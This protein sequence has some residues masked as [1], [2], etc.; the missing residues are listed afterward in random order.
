MEQK[1]LRTTAV[2]GETWPACIRPRNEEQKTKQ[3]LLMSFTRRHAR[4]SALYEYYYISGSNSKLSLFYDDL[5]CLRK[6]SPALHQWLLS[7]FR[8][9]RQ[10]R[11]INHTLTCYLMK[12]NV[13][14]PV[15][16]QK[17]QKDT[18]LDKQGIKH[19]VFNELCMHDTR[20]LDLGSTHWLFQFVKKDE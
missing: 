11:T 6:R 4:R 10:Q 1:R 8:T 12:I 16:N 14:L 7:L 19:K 3:L 2:E 20:R 13:N 15:C 9:Q 17:Q 18:I 5:I